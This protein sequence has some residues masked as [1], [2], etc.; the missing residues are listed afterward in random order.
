MLLCNHHSEVSNLYA[1]ILYWSVYE[2]LWFHPVLHPHSPL[3]LDIL[4][5]GQQL[6]GPEPTTTDKDKDGDTVQ[7]WQA[8]VCHH[9]DAAAAAAAII[10]TKS[11][12]CPALAHSK[13]LYCMFQMCFHFLVVKSGAAIYA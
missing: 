7:K 10:L 4:T 12:H 6:D 3:S 1:L 11:I 9:L 5:E 2:K 8:K 13:Y